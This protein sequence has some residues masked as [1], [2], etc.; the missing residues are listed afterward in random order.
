MALVLEDC[1]DVEWA[2]AGEYDVWEAVQLNNVRE[3]EAG[4][5]QAFLVG[6]GAHLNPLCED[7]D[8]EKEVFRLPSGDFTV[9]GDHADDLN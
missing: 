9:R 7:F 8:G 4:E 2:V 6:N 1:H 5:C 3:E